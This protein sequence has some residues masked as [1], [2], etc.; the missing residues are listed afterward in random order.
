M[1]KQKFAPIAGWEKA[2]SQLEAWAVF[3][4]VFMGDYWVHPSTYKLF[5]LLKDISRVS[6][7]L[8]PQALQ[9]PTFPAILLSLIQQEFNESFGQALERR[10]RVQCPNFERLHRALATGNFRPDIVALPGR[11][12]PTEHPLYPPAAPCR[13]ASATP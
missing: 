9:K 11:L 1:G 6:P 4:T 13:Q 8:R 5:L 10:Q 7:S 3:C 2:A 12:A